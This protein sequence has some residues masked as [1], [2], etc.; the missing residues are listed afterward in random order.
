MPPTPVTTTYLELN[1]PTVH[2]DTVTNSD[3]YELIQSQVPSP[4]LNRFL[5]CSVG[6]QYWWYERVN[7]SYD[8]WMT[9]LDTEKVQTWVAYL[10]GTP[11]GYFELER[12]PGENVE[13]AYFGLLPQFVGHGLG[14]L[15]LTDAID[16]AWAFGAKRVWVHTCTLDHPAALGNYHARGFKVFK[17]ETRDEN[18]PDEALVPW[19]DY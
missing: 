17:E 15:L 9:W 16:R 2:N 18:L 1:N 11:I 19:P 3:A 13:I 4:E 10:Q 5:Y 6:F 14:E 8:Q 12:Q 7:W